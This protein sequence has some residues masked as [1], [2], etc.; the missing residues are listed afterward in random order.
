MENT[1]INPRSNQISESSMKVLSN[2][3]KL[4]S[5][6]LV[7]SSMCAVAAMSFG[8]PPVNPLLFLL[9]YFVVLFAVVKARNSVFA[10]PLT[11]LLTGL[12]GYTLGPI[13]SAY[14]SLPNGASLVGQSLLATGLIFGA[15]SVY[16]IKTKQVVSAGVQSFLA[17]GMLTVFVM[18]LLNVFFFQ[19]G[20]LSLVCS[21]FVVFISSGIMMWQIS[22]IVNDGEDNYVMATVTLFVQLYNLL[23]SILN[24]LTAFTGSN[25]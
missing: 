24:I 10:L 8:V 5:L 21:S 20:V 9:L 23:L 22:D 15:I 16:T 2:T 4:L 14:A 1:T 25:D 11:F 19:S 6:N 17:I 3:Y 13:L 7:T 12:L 18:S